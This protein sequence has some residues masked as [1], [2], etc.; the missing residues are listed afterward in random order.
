MKYLL[1]LTPITHISLGVCLGAHKSIMIKPQRPYIIHSTVQ[2]LCK[3]TVPFLLVHNRH[4]LIFF[5]FL[6][7]LHLF[8]LETDLPL[9]FR[10]LAGS[11]MWSPCSR[12]AIAT[13]ISTNGHVTHTGPIWIPFTEK[14]KKM[15]PLPC[16]SQLFSKSGPGDTSGHLPSYMERACLRMKPTE[17]KA[18]A[19]DSERQN[20]STWL[21]LKFSFIW[22]NKY[23]FLLS[24]YVFFKKNR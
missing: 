20:L 19:R 8:L 2:T 17:R 5:F 14:E 22:D 16:I 4:W 9:L 11:I 23:P 15:H 24:K 3:A 13:I 21:I 7:H 12:M 1:T 10:L 6:S 18:E